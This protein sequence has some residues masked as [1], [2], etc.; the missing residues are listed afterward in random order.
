MSPGQYTPVETWINSREQRE[1]ALRHRVGLGGERWSEHTGS[2]PDLKPGQ[3]EFMQNQRAAGSLARRWS[4][5]GIIIE[6]QEYDRCLVKVDS[7]GELLT[8]LGRVFTM[9]LRFKTVSRPGRVSK[10]LLQFRTVSQPGRVSTMLL[11][12]QTMS[13]PHSHPHQPTCCQEAC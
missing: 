8:E 11:Q 6:N 1:I 10:M 2:L 12:F 3:H 13:Q 5:T 7:S 4:R 9:L